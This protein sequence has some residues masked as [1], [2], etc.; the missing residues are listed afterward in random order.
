MAM[1]PDA[2]NLKD[3]LFFPDLVLLSFEGS[4][5]IIFFNEILLLLD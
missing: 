1:L 3:V 5:L 4:N 2:L